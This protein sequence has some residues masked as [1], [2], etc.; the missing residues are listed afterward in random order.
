MFEEEV[1]VAVSGGFDPLHVGHLD[2]F[3]KA[4]KLG[5]RL[6]VI[7]NKDDFLINKKGYCFM[8][9]DERVEIL[10][11]ID[12]V[13]EVMRSIDDDMTVKNSLYYRVPDIFV[14]GGDRHNDEIPEAE[15]CRKC[16]IEMVDGAG[17]K[18]Q[19]SSELVENAIEQIYKRGV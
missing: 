13:D 16:G 11:H 3:K 2:L 17:N 8:T 1:E 15:T 19:S 4:K 12:I 5:D 14:N 18:I 7:V 10:S 9:L 6:I